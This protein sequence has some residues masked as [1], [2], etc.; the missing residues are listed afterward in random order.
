M[1]VAWLSHAGYWALFAGMLL[2]SAG[3]PLPS[4]VI[5][6]FGG[7]LVAVG[8]VTLLGALLATLAGGLVGGILL[9]II[10]RYGGR[11]LLVRY[12]RYVLIR[13]RHLDEADR[14][15]ARYGGW[16]V[17][18]GRLLPVVRTYISLPAGVAEMPFGPFLLYSLIGSAPWTLAL[19]LAG[20]A[21]GGNWQSIGHAVS[22]VDAVLVLVVVVIVALLLWRRRRA[23]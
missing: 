20:R 15:F 3:I 14:F 23:S 9:Y 22:R 16:S 4:E 19:L 2:E 21:L 12:G 5:L 17:V 10:G 8:R 18:I 13:E 11:P 1:V 6:P 7:Y